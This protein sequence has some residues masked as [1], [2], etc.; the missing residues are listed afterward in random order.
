MSLP[1]LTQPC[2]DLSQVISLA[3]AIYNLIYQLS[4]GDDIAEAAVYFVVNLLLLFVLPA[5]GYF[6]AQKRDQSLIV[7]FSWG[8]GCFS[9]LGFVS[10]WSLVYY[11]ATS[12]GSVFLVV[13]STIS[14]AF[15]AFYGCQLM[16]DE[17]FRGEQGTSIYFSV[18]FSRMTDFSFGGRTFSSFPALLVLFADSL[19]SI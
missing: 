16:Q 12:V 6:G 9:F 7:C 15:A 8:S 14:Q 1:L 4:L 13:A 5:C 18:F 10:L 19:R 17:G 2:F 3:T 11:Y